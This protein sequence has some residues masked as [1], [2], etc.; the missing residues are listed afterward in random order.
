MTERSAEN[1]APFGPLVLPQLTL[2]T[3][4]KSLEC[5][6]RPHSLRLLVQLAGYMMV[7]A[8]PSLSAIELDKRPVFLKQDE[9]FFVTVFL[10][11]LHQS[12]DVFNL[13]K[14]LSMTMLLFPLFPSTR[15]VH[16]CSI[17]KS[18]T[19]PVTWIREF[20]GQKLEMLVQ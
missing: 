18:C 11:L 12:Y 1:R 6:S 16:G 8:R 4:E 2:H 13:N 5:S 20:I 9:T 17:K 7:K 15:R 14:E 10:L 3:N 19:A